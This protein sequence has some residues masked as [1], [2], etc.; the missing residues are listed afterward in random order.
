M[1]KH[2]DD[3]EKQLS[4]RRGAVIDKNRERVKDIRSLINISSCCQISKV[5][6]LAYI[7]SVERCLNEIHGN[8]TSTISLVSNLRFLFETCVN[9]RILNKEGSY[10]YKVHYAI[11]QSQI[12][13]S[14]S[15]IKYTQIDL[16]RLDILELEEEKLMPKTTN[17]QEL[18][19]NFANIEK[20]YDE[21]DEEIS[22]FLEA[23]SFNGIDLQRHYI[24]KYLAKLN[25]KHNIM[26]AEWENAKQNL[27][28]DKEFKKHF[29]C[30]HQTS[31]VEKELKDSRSWREKSDSVG[32]SEIYGFVY[33]Y[34]SSLIHSNS[35]SI[36]IPNELD[37]IEATMIKSLSNRLSADI[38]KNLK[39]FASIPNVRVIHIS[40]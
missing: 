37:D 17:I 10:K 5:L 4:S 7:D 25:E 15:L 21:I 3:I 9:T 2:S 35:Y 1:F 36:M 40:E 19:E 38:L 34:A 18:K 6:T 20:L 11:Y 29:N 16:A 24:Q 28:N 27:V 14:A 12:T 23:V 39:D 30:T 32:L 13:K 22:L 33:D 31:K 26:I 8:S